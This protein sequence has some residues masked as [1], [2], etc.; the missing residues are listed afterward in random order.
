[1]REV[2][3]SEDIMNSRDVVK[4]WE[5]LVEEREELEE[6]ITDLKTELLDC[7]DEEEKERLEANLKEAEADL[8]EFEEDDNYKALKEFNE[9]GSSTFDSEWDF[10]VTL[11]R[12]DYFTE[13]A[14]EFAE[15]IGNV[16][17]SMSWP[18]NCI[19]WEKAADQLKQDY[20]SIDFNGETYW[21][22]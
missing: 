11:I 14:Q 12:D 1:M 21:G 20:I 15:D 10:G 18:C 7:E 17:R 16:Q 8:K 6:E 22:R 2:S 9:E 4:A 3:N 13:Y 5:K 19:D